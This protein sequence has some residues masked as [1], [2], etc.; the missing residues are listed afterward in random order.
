MAVA[1]KFQTEQAQS[2]FCNALDKAQAKYE[3]SYAGPFYII[4]VKWQFS[5]SALP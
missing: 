1:F 5:K 2:D 4:K 3:V